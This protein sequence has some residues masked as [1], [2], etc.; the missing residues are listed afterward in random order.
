MGNK[1][2]AHRRWTALA[3][4]SVALLL[5]A[6]ACAAPPT[7]SYT[8]ETGQEVTVN[9]KDYPVSAGLLPEDFSHAVTQ[10]EAQATSDAVL[11]DIRAAL[12]SVHAFEWSTRGEAAWFPGGGNGYGGK[13][14]TST[15]NSTQWESATAPASNA[16]WE[17]I[18]AV[19]SRITTKHGLGGVQLLFDH[20]N[21]K[22]DHSWQKDL[23][24]KYGTADPQR[25]WW[26]EGTAYTRSQWLVLHMV[27]VDRDTTGAAAK[28][29]EDSGLPARSISIS[30]GAT[31]VPAKDQ[32]ALTQA[33]EPFVGLTPP[34][35]T[36]SD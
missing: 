24:D 22:T 21:F 1:S 33:L 10:E 27:N 5:G 23:I 30:Y 35:A 11:T 36:T 29:T 17:E 28:E 26:W 4:A 12:T 15:F 2:A 9:W 18:V 8:N 32:A 34:E 20:E 13:V 7:T 6:S 25:L 14:M 31:A 16:E 19:T 3:A